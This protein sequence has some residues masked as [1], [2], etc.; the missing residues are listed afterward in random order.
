MTPGHE[1]KDSWNQIIVSSYNTIA[2]Q[3]HT[4]THTHTERCPLC[5]SLHTQTPIELPNKYHTL[6]GWAFNNNN[7]NN[8]PEYCVVTRENDTEVVS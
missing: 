4:H 3:P 6:T 7:N 2:H 8:T 5:L 1:G